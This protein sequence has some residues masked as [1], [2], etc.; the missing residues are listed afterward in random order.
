MNAVRHIPAQRS[1]VLGSAFHFAA[2]A[3]LN[4]NPEADRE[5]VLGWVLAEVENLNGFLGI[6]ACSQ[7]DCEME[8]AEIAR[9]V[10]SRL[11]PVLNGLRCAVEAGR[12]DHANLEE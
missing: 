4:V 6:I 1:A 11:E 5:D 2:N 3:A 10:F 7:S 9:L 8:P 12:D